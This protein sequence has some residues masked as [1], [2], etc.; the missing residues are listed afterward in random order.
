[1]LN[2]VSIYLFKINNRNRRTMR[3]TFSTWEKLIK[4][5]PERCHYGIVLSLL[6]TLTRF[7]ILFWCVYCWLSPSK[8]R[9]GILL[10]PIVNIY[11]ESRSSHQRCSIRKG[12]L[13]NFTKFTGKHLCQSLLKKRFWH[14]CFPVNF[15][16]FLRTP[17][18]TEYLRWLLLWILIYMLN[19][20]T[21]FSFQHVKIRI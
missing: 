1:M 9:L 3:K 5:T 15:A 11:I 13:K 10:K 19:Y 16:K 20:K 18:L 4:K 17:F 2:P 7:H 14:R 6:L 8:C 21:S 12:V